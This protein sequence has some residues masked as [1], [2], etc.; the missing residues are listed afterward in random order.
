VDK[1]FY[2]DATNR[3]DTGTGQ[4]E[5]VFYV[6]GH[7]DPANPDESEK[8]Y[9][10]CNKDGICE[11]SWKKFQLT[12]KAQLTVTKTGEGT[13]S[14]T[15]SNCNPTATECKGAYYA[16]DQATLT[17]TF[18]TGFKFVNWSGDCS[19]T[20][21]SVTV[22]M[23]KDKSCT[24][25]FVKTF[26][27]TTT[28]KT[29]EG[30][31]SA[32]SATG[33]DC[34]TN[35]TKIYDT[36][37]SVVL[38]AMP[39]TGFRFDSWS[40]A[41]GCDGK[42]SPVT[43]TMD[44]D[45]TCM[46]N[47][48]KTFELTTTSKT[49]EGTISATSATGIDCDTNCTKIYDA[50]T[51]VVLTANPATGFRFDSWSGGC[52]DKVSPVTV[53]MDK[54]KSCTANFVQTFELT[55]TSKT[56]E[57]T[58]SATSATGIDCDTNCTKIYD[59]GTSVVLTATAADDFN[60]VSWTGEEDCNGTNLSVTVTMNKDK[61]CTATFIKKCAIDDDSCQIMGPLNILTNFSPTTY[62]NA[63]FVEEVS[64]GNDKNF[65]NR[66]LTRDDFGE[67]STS[68]DVVTVGAKITVAP[69][70]VQKPADI[71]V[72]VLVTESSFPGWYMLKSP[73]APPTGFPS[74]IIP[75][76]WDQKSKPDAF[77]SVPNLPQ[78]QEQ[79]DVNIFSGHLPYYGTGKYDIYVGYRL[80]GNDQIINDQIIY[81]P[82][83][84]H[85]EIQ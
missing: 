27:L 79:L 48:V 46:A 18:A 9:V 53:I 63:H 20:D 37:T 1:S 25:N 4:V 85:F 40:E 33:I 81:G 12:N 58:I 31:I 42:I 84:I 52:D 44:K 51:S 34:N 29:A 3:R 60:F 24:A 41:E 62:Q 6:N 57:G 36:G 26:E 66:P 49:A 70:D 82:K 45:K 32:T 67:N 83:P 80:T 78:T 28:S 50:G 21:S 10:S 7:Y 59:V 39:V 16:G 2:F 72:L 17:A 55:T 73:I 19:G 54:D 15:E 74:T 11:G 8:K 23:D 35:C 14:A 56:A 13:I 61:T 76:V 65:L 30:T 75:A 71:L 69:E 47:F 22:T 38:T 64:I 5:Y 68:N 43:V 77:F